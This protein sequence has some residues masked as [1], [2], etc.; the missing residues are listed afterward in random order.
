M[1]LLNFVLFPRAR[2][3]SRQGLIRG[4]SPEKL[5]VGCSSPPRV[6]LH[7]RPEAPLRDS[8]L[9]QSEMQRVVTEVGQSRVHGIHAGTRLGETEHRGQGVRSFAQRQGRGDSTV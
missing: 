5:I 3:W 6:I 9:A 4:W 2:S 8:R 1:Y 7:C